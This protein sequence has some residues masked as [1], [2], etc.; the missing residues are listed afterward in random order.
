MNGDQLHEEHW[1]V[2]YEAY[3]RGWL[4]SSGGDYISSDKYFN[5]LRVN[6]VRFTKKFQKVTKHTLEKIR[7]VRNGYDDFDDDDD[8]TPFYQ[9]DE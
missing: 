7:L 2:A 4:S 8:D 5:W 6:G 1:L 9:D 3:E